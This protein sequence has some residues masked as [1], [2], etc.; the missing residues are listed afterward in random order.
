MAYFKY[1]ALKLKGK[2]GTVAHLKALHHFRQTLKDNI[3]GLQDKEWRDELE[4]ILKRTEAKIRTVEDA[5]P[6]TRLI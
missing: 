3:L 6:G 2:Q 4:F 5:L 1:D